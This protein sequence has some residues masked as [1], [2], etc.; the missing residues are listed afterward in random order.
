MKLSDKIT[1]PFIAYAYAGSVSFFTA[2]WQAYRILGYVGNGDLGRAAEIAVAMKYCAIAL[3]V[4]AA[5]AEI[6]VSFSGEED[7]AGG[8][9]MGI[10]VALIAIAIGTAATAIGSVLRKKIPATA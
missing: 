6:V 2:L 9:F 8:V 1:D 4:F 5:G 7:R 10:L 3:F